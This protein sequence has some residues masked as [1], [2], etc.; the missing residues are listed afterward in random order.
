M[1]RCAPLAD[2][3]ILPQWLPQQAAPVTVRRR[4]LSI[5]A[6]QSKSM[7]GTLTS[8]ARHP[9][10]HTTLGFSVHVPS[11]SAILKDMFE[12]RSSKLGAN[13]PLCLAAHAACASYNAA[14]AC[15][16]DQVGS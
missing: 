10:L 15:R 16:I 5:T 13:W 9:F 3:I 2:R 6:A 8:K 4:L 1:I 11:I 14:A 12:L 7:A